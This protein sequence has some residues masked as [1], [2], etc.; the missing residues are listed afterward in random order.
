[1]SVV[2]TARRTRFTRQA[3]QARIDIIAG[4]MRPVAVA[5]SG[6]RRLL[7]KNCKFGYDLPNAF[8]LIFDEVDTSG[9]SP[10]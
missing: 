9:K 7:G 6:R 4:I 3:N 5:G 8:C 1:M 2:A 10:A